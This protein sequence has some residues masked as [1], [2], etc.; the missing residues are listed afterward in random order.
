MHVLQVEP[1]IMTNYVADGRVRLDQD[2]SE[3]ELD[4]GNIAKAR[5][6]PD[7]DSLFT[8]REETR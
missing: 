7:Y 6:V 3:V 8:K 5:L 4:M 2:G 1:Q